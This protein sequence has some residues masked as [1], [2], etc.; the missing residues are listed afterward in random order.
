LQIGW[1]LNEWY[2]DVETLVASPVYWPKLSTSESPVDGAGL[3]RVFPVAFD[4]PILRRAPRH[5]S[6]LAFSS[7]GSSHSL[8]HIRTAS[9]LC[10][11]RTVRDG[12]FID[13][14]SNV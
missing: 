10:W 8:P 4:F 5:D 6:V 13:Q 11:R 12:M 3:G 1:Q 14:I 7:P 2:K 9:K